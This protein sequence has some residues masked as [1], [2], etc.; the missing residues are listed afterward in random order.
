M[1]VPHTLGHAPSAWFI[2]M[3]SPGAVFQ[4]APP[5]A[6][7]FYFDASDAGVSVTVE[8]W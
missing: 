8:A 4:A 1:T 6:T 5:D 3:R 2:L 7:A